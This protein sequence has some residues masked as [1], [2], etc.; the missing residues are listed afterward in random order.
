M[1]HKHIHGEAT[2]SQIM[3]QWCFSCFFL[4]KDLWGFYIDQTDKNEK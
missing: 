1:I 4:K 2:N 3:T